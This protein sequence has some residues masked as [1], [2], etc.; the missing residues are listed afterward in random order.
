[1]N[2]LL[3]LKFVLPQFQVE[4]MRAANPSLR[5]EVAIGALILIVSEFFQHLGNR[6]AMITVFNFVVHVLLQ[7]LNIKVKIIGEIDLAFRH[8]SKLTFTM[9]DSGPRRL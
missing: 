1:M 2:H 5:L 9:R 3:L 6:S 7:V 8:K 4:L